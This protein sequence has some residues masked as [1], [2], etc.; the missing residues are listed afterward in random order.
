MEFEIRYYLGE[1]LHE[2]IFNLTASHEDDLSRILTAAK[3]CL[4]SIYGERKFTLLR[5]KSFNTD[6][7]K[8]PLPKSI[9]EKYYVPDI[10][11]L[12]TRKKTS[13]IEDKKK[14]TVRSTPR[15]RS[16]MKTIKSSIRT[17]KKR[18]KS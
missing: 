9:L 17:T 13:S 18:T 8:G 12:A 5:V 15:K 4:N 1:K 14:E 10:P 2:K 7:Y 3:K 6:N 11:K 16:A